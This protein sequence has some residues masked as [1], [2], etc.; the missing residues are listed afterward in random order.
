MK[1]FLQSLLYLITSLYNI[2][3]KIYLYVNKRIAQSTV[4]SKTRSKFQLLIKNYAK[5]IIK[6]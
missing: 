5:L 2:N 1:I 3:N 6:F 4:L